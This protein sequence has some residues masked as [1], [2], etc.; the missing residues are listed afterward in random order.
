MNRIPG[1][2][3]CVALTLGLT[4]LMS[5]CGEEEGDTSSNENQLTSV[6][7]LSTTDPYTYSLTIAASGQG[8]VLNLANNINCTNKV[9]EHLIE[10]GAQL[11]LMATAAKGYLFDHWQYQCAGITTQECQISMNADIK[12][13]A[14]FVEE[15]TQLGNLS[16]AWKEP[17]AREDGSTFTSGEIQQYVIYYRENQS[18]PYAGAERITVGNSRSGSVP[19]EVTINNLEVGKRYYLAGITIDTNGIS[20]QLSN[21]IV[22]VVY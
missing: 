17:T 15:S 1:W 9:C 20:S 6:T 18:D 14:V 5:G 4:L 3:K 8:S 21:E 19:T 12:V 22:R 13:S 16:V 10:A 2:I 11:N 7:N